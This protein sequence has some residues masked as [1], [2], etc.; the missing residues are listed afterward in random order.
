MEVDLDVINRMAILEPRR[1]YFRGRKEID[2]VCRQIILAVSDHRL[3]LLKLKTL[4]LLMMISN[5]DLIQSYDLP[6]YLSQKN[7]QLA[8]NVR[9][10]ITN[11]RSC[12]LTLQQL[13]EE[14]HTSPTAIKSAFKNVYGESIREY[15]KSIRL[16][17]ARRMFRETDWSI[18]EV[19]GMVGYSNPGHF[20][21]AFREKFAMTPGDYKKFVRNEG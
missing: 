2:T 18:A 21:V 7:V 4:E 1:F 10:R 15:M 16:Q 9:K 14:L 20:A 19:A 13:S 3:P 17:E 6:V 8:K 12:H 5:P 11:D